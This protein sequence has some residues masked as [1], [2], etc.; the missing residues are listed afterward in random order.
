MKN[1]FAS[2]V[3]L[4][5]LAVPALAQPQSQ[6]RP[7]GST[8]PA[9]TSLPPT[10]D[11]ENY[12]ID[13]TVL[14]EEGKIEGRADIVLRVL[15]RNAVAT[16][17][18]DKHFKVTKLTVGNISPRYR[19]FEYDSTLEVDLGGGAA[20]DG[21]I[22]LHVEYYGLFDAA[23]DRRNSVLNYV[24]KDSAYLLYEGKWFPTNGLYKDKAAMQLTVKAPAGWSVVADLPPSGAGFASNTPSFWGT[25]AL[26]K[27]SA[28]TVKSGDND[29]TVYTIKAPAA[30]VSPLA[31]ASSK[32]LDFYTSKFG[33]LTSRQFHIIETPDANWTSRWSMGSLLLPTSQF[34]SEVDIPALARTIARQ[35]FPLKMSIADPVNDAWLSDGM[36]VFASLLYGEKNLSPAEFDEQVGKV[37]V[38]A[39]AYE[40]S[41]T[42]RQAGGTEKDSL[43]Y[44]SLVENKG[45]YVFRMLQWLIGNEKFDK[46]MTRYVE[47]FKDK[48]VSAAAFIKL[49]SDVHGDDLGYFFDQWVSS[50]GVPQLDANYQVLRVKNGY[51]INGEIKQDLDLFR[52]PVELVIM[53]DDEPEY[54]RVDVIGPNSDFSVNSA[55]KPKPGGIMIDPRKKILR[56]SPDI[57][58]AVFINRGEESASEMRYNDA[59]EAYQQALELDGNSSLAS[60]R[61]AEARFEGGD[62]NTA[63]QLFRDSLN[64]DLK[65]KWIEVWA[66]INIGKIYDLRGGQRDRAVQEYQ[67]AVNTG[68][69]SYGA[70]AAAKEYLMTPF[71]QAPSN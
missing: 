19:Q 34:R 66:H 62:I 45:A 71:R 27:Y 55:R 44:K 36:A 10:L 46:L 70:Q 65:P 30:T 59:V 6:L 63:V 43:E 11:V 35:W 56:M 7:G 38:K 4:L 40:G 51:M 64:G 58:V 26:G 68:D 28:T 29:I 23:E 61:M 22:T 48:P 67:K 39:L 14:P 2:V 42:M 41:M 52:M 47:Q 50:S 5:A 18:L 13:L 16:F 69:D 1:A 21:A 54:K 25:L 8:S 31:A 37:L 49:A 9:L 32:I 3:V 57:R 12:K 24:S 17:D 20:T 33:P 60:F 53:T 15:E